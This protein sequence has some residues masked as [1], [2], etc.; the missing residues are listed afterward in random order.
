[1]LVEFQYRVPNQLANL[2]KSNIGNFNGDYILGWVKTKDSKFLKSRSLYLICES[3]EST[4]GPIGMY[5][6]VGIVAK[7]EYEALDIYNKVTGNTN[8]IFH[9]KILDK[10]NNLKVI[11][12]GRTM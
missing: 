4:E 12:T 3:D 1:M 5:N 2:M 8:G 6:P 9:S 7:T 11:P 10:C